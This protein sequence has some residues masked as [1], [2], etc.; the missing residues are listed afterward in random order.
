MPTPL[1]ELRAVIRR[2]KDGKMQT[3]V[4]L[5]RQDVFEYEEVDVTHHLPGR[6]NSIREGLEREKG[7]ERGSITLARWVERFKEREFEGS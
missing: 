2:L 5:L 1:Y 7:L 4:Q 3:T 6:L